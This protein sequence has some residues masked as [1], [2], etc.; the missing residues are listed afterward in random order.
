MKH[1]NLLVVLILV[2]SLV[3]LAG[4]SGGGDPCADLPDADARNK[5]YLDEAVANKDPALCEK[6]TAKSQQDACAE[7]AKAE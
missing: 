6:I 7:Q 1:T 3:F 2:G 5:C 4:C